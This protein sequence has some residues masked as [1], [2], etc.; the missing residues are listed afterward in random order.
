[1]RRH[2]RAD[3]QNKETDILLWA[4]PTE[5]V[6]Q[7]PGGG[8]SESCLQLYLPIGKKLKGMT[9]SNKNYAD[10]Q[11]R[12]ISAWMLGLSEFDEAEFD[13]QVEKITVQPDG[14]LLYHFYDGRT[15]LWQR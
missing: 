10:Y 1:M 2:Y 6:E 7:P 8:S 3:P 15:S 11:L 14:N 12:N 13:K 4:M 5:M 9:C